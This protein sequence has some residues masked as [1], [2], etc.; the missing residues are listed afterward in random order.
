MWARA[1]VEELMAR[2]LGG[3]QSGDFPEPLEG[4]IV[5]IALAHRLLTPFTSFVAVEDRV[6]NRGG[7]S[8]TVR[9]PVEMPDGVR[10]EGVFGES[11]AGSAADASG[12]YARQS[13]AAARAAP[14]KHAQVVAAA[15]GERRRSSDLDALSDEEAE[16]RG[17]GVREQAP[18]SPEVRRRLAPALLTLLE[19]GPEARGAAAAVDGWVRVQV[20]LVDASAAAIRA[21]QA[22]GFQIESIDRLRIVGVARADDL[23][24]LAASDAVRRVEPAPEA[25]AGSGVG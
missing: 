25:A 24:R 17:D 22:A 23:A 16:P 18:L 13:L 19:R 5:R 6:V 14:A 3:M 8:V 15:P 1:K 2:D 21:L 11:A 7:E 20:E 10:Y 4:Q 9:V 12:G